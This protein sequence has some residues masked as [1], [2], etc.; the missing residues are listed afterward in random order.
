[1]Y[2][3]ILKV[4]TLCETSHVCWLS[5]LL[6]FPLLLLQLLPHCYCNCTPPVSTSL[7]PHLPLTASWRKPPPPPHLWANEQQA[8]FHLHRDYSRPPTC[9]HTHTH[10]P[11]QASLTYEAYPCKCNDTAKCTRV[12]RHSGG[13]SYTSVIF[14]IRRGEFLQRPLKG[15][16]DGRRIKDGG[17]RRE[18]RAG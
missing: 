17:E 6:F 1:M 16:K 9:A 14:L 15:W 7:H 18:R 12:Q 11:W 4:H 2:Y 5:S 3:L 8:G 10:P 13:C